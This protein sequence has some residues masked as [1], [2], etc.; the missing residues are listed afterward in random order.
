[1]N[2]INIRGKITSNNCE[3]EESIYSCIPQ[4]PRKD[5]E[6]LVPFWKYSDVSQS[7]GG[8]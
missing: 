1:M 5:A 6:L 7:F 3:A 2:E 4:S 8:T